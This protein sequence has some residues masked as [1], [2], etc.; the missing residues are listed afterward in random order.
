MKMPKV[1]EADEP[2]NPKRIYEDLINRCKKA[3]LYT[4]DCIIE[5]S[6]TGVAP[7]SIRIEDGVFSCSVIAT[8]K[9]DAFLQVVNCLPVI[10]FLTSQDEND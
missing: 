8:N 3:K 5:E 4:I 7:F 2:K 9:R 10:R 1:I 6:W